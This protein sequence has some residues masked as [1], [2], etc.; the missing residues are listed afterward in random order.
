MADSQP[1]NGVLLGSDH[2]KSVTFIPYSAFLITLG[3][4]IL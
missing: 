4:L 2:S 1:D 3:V